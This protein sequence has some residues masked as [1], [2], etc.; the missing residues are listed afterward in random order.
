MIQERF[1]FCKLKIK[2]SFGLKLEVIFLFFVPII[3]IRIFYFRGHRYTNVT[4]EQV[5]FWA[6]I[7]YISLLSTEPQKSSSRT[8]VRD[9][10]SPELSLFSFCLRSARPNAITST[11]NIYFSLYP[12]TLVQCFFFPKHF[13]AFK[14]GSSSGM[15]FLYY[16]CG[17]EQN[18]LF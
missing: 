1:V 12:H 13:I 15:Y 4:E 6:P 7:S 2:K 5:E 11:S 10:T 14:T 9:L 18:F 17:K 3:Y 8:L 16:R